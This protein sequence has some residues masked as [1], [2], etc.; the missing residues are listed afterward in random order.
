[1][2]EEEQACRWVLK[3]RAGSEM[4]TTQEF[5]SRAAAEEWLGQWWS[6]LLQEGAESVV[7]LDAGDAAYEMSLRA[8][9]DD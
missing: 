9:S 8:E 1:M 2:S 4:R 5:E 3:D 7:L 6:S